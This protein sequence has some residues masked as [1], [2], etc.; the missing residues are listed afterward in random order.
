MTFVAG[1]A[2]QPSLRRRAIPHLPAFAVMAKARKHCRTSPRAGLFGPV[3]T[4]LPRLAKAQSSPPRGRLTSSVGIDPPSSPRPVPLWCVMPVFFRFP[5]IVSWCRGGRKFSH[6]QHLERLVRIAFR[7]QGFMERPARASQ[8]TLP[9][10]NGGLA[11]PPSAL[12]R[13]RPGCMQNGR[14]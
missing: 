9:A 4:L 3:Q 11:L 10:L 8:G 7:Q 13:G 12:A 6:E 5:I 14:Y 2:R 1:A